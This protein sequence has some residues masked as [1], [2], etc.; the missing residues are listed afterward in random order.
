MAIGVTGLVRLDDVSR[1]A[2]GKRPT[3]PGPVGAFY[4]RF[5]TVM[6]ATPDAMGAVRSK[7]AVANFGFVLVE[8]LLVKDTL[9]SRC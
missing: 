2:A 7:L 5:M 9:F 6:G 4:Y 8:L 1:Y 3:R